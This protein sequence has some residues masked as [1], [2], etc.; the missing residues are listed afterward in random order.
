[1]FRRK[2]N[3]RGEGRLRLKAAADEQLRQHA[4]SETALRAELQTSW[5][6]MQQLYPNDQRK[7]SVT[8]QAR[9]TME[10]QER[11]IDELKDMM[12]IFTADVKATFAEIA[13]AQKGHELGFNVVR[14]ELRDLKGGMTRVVTKTQN[15]KVRWKNG[16]SKKAW[17]PGMESRKIPLLS[18][19]GLRQS[20]RELWASI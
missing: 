9:R 16:L 8:A 18:K 11:K 1:M 4:V 5:N 13:H 3:E 19:Q 2:K 6:Q 15:L 12:S 20:R 7:A 10:L 17:K 14:A